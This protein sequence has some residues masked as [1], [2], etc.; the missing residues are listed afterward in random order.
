M[1]EPTMRLAE[2]KAKLILRKKK[3]ESLNLKVFDL[4]DL[5]PQCLS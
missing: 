5:R 3:Q 2:D 1:F 4:K